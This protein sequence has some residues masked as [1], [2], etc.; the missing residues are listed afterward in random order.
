MTLLRSLALLCLSRALIAGPESVGNTSANFLKIPINARPA[1]M[2][3]AFGALSDD[4]AALTYNPAG[5]AGMIQGDLSATHIQWFQGI[6]LEHL[7]G[8]FRVGDYGAGGVS[9]T[10]LQVD[11]MFRTFRNAGSYDP[12]TQFDYAGTFAPHDVALTLAYAEELGPG[13]F[14]GGGLKLIQQNVEAYN[15]YGAALDLGTQYVGLA[16]GLSLGLVLRQIGFP[17]AVADTNFTLPLALN[18]SALY[19]AL[20]SQLNFVAETSLSVDND[21][22]TGIGMEG[23]IKNILALRAGYRFGYLNGYTAGAG[24][25]VGGLKLDY[26]FVPYGELGHTHRITAGLAFGG[27]M[28]YVDADPAVFAP[29]GFARF[30]RT[31]LY[32]DAPS[33]RRMLGWK[34][35]IKDAAGVEAK[36]FRGEGPVPTE[37]AWDGRDREGRILPDGKYTA[38]LEAQFPRVSILSDPAF[39]ELD[40]SPPVTSLDVAPKMIRPEDNTGA[41][42]IPCRFKPVAKDIHG[43]ASWSFE[44]RDDHDQLFWSFEG[45]GTPPAEILWDGSNGKGEFVESGR[46]YAT[47][48]KAMDRL[49][50]LNPGEPVNQVILLREIRLKMADAVFFDSGKADLKESGF[51]DIDSIAEAI[52][53]YRGEG[54]T[55]Y[56]EGHTDSAPIH[57][58]RFPDNDALSLARAQA[59]VDYLVKNKGLDIADFEA[60]G[61]GSRVPVDDND[62]P[63]GM[64]HNRRVI[65]VIR[66]K[67]YK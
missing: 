24:M 56:I 46:I 1:A 31:N 27:P 9:L 6:H 12:A 23:W 13:W 30:H 7:G 37:M 41:I 39:L 52:K 48:F 2:G 19:S 20:K 67:Y 14:V 34:M 33:R 22:Q 4:E 29:M 8:T 54:T 32:V 62:N 16:E 59:L 57:S 36:T 40:D 17:I 50:N 55:V 45:K 53:K 63:E 11:E 18:A 44:I 51:K 28:M 3:E 43:V 25:Y 65:V 47:T 5:L 66:T 21:L 10:W 49:G 64:A 61:F 60:Q 42:L 35:V 58:K 38:R 15:G 26:A